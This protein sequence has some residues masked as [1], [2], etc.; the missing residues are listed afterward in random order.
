MFE[1]G[2]GSKINDHAGVD[3]GILER[4]GLEN[5]THITPKLPLPGGKIME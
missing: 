2:Q 4:G 1:Q 3:P 5:G